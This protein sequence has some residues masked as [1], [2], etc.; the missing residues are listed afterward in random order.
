MSVDAK[1]AKMTD[2]SSV[3][4]FIKDTQ[5]DS[6]AVTIGNVHG[7]YSQ[8][9]Q[10]DFLRLEA[11]RRNVPTGFPLVL[12]GASGLPKELVMGAIT[13]GVCKFN[14]NTD[15]RLAAMK[16][17]RETMISKP[18]VRCSL[19][20]IVNKTSFTTHSKITNLRIFY[21]LLSYAPLSCINHKIRHECYLLNYSLIFSDG[22]SSA[23]GNHHH[24]YA[25][26]CTRKNRV[27]SIWN[28]S[29]KESER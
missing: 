3:A 23:D 17:V 16:V 1:E 7:T 26:C 27:I 28:T 4:M 9:P 21:S 20:I 8:P 2:P 12:H 24:S 15:L 14:V 25:G 19:C 5:V 11:I 22:R 6:L 18:K 29:S 10:L 13:R